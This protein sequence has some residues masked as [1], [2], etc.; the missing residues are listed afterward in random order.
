MAITST[1]MDKYFEQIQTSPKVGELEDAECKIVS[2]AE[3][4]SSKSGKTSIKITFEADNGAEFGSYLGISNDKAVDITNAKLTQICAAAVGEEEMKKLF[5]DSYTDEDVNDTKELALDF[6]VKVNKK[7]KKTPV[8]AIVNRH[9]DEGGMWNVK[10]RLK[11][12]ESAEKT[13]TTTGEDFYDSL[14]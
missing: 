10:W 9:K 11:S 6:C 1:D 12:D 3:Y 13:E 14:K 4:K 5:K 8:I 7:I 2:V